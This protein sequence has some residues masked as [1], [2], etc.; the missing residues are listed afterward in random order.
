M[1][2]LLLCMFLCIASIVHAETNWTRTDTA[3][4]VAWQAIN[5]IDWG[6]TLDIARNPEDYREYNPILGKHPSVGNVNLYML[7]SALIHPIISYILPPKIRPYWQ[8]ITIGLSGA[9]VI[10]N[11]AVGLRVKF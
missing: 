1:K 10:N 11:A 8:Y 7:S 6:Q 2:S 3:R 5:I 4:E 9:C